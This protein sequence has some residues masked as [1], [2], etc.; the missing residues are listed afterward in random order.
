MNSSLLSV[1][2]IQPH[3]SNFVSNIIEDRWEVTKEES[4][5]FVRRYLTKR[6][7][8]NCFVAVY[9][10]M[11]IGME[12]FNVSNDIGVDLHPWCIGLWV[13]PKYRGYG[14]GNKLTLRIF[15][16][17]K[18]M[19]YEKIYLDTVSAEPYHLKFGWRRSG[20]I[21]MHRGVPTVVMEHDLIN[22]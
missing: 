16:W 19:G 4:L 21:G 17:A 1:V 11:P 20:I 3:H 14:I 13:N 6:N 15:N 5:S 8:A 12:A 2:E 9:D 7:S 18:K 10:D 22:I